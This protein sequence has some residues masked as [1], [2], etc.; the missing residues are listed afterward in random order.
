MRCVLGWLALCVGCYSPAYAPGGPCET[1]CPGD[2]VCIDHVCRERDYQPPGDAPVADA[3]VPVDTVDAP[4]GDQDGDGIDD[5]TDNCPAHANPDQ[6]DE[7]G[8]AI[9]DVCDPCPHVAGT[10]ADSDGDGVGDACDPQP[11]IAKQRIR[12]FDPFTSARPE[13]SLSASASRVGETLRIDAGS[14]G[15]SA[16]LFVPNGEARLHV[17]GTIVSVGSATPRQVSVSFGATSSS[18]YHYCELWDPGAVSIAITKRAGDDY[19]WIAQNETDMPMPTGPWAMRIDESVAAQ[20]IEISA[21][22]G[23]VAYPK[24]AADA[25]SAPPL[26]SGSSATIFARNVDVRLDYFIVIETLP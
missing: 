21:T 3:Y 25:S 22:L 23:G 12:F 2:L 15:G 18:V 14:S 4:P 19:M 9:G 20:H 7:D 6:H 11:N 5:A 24:L 17:G 1:S 10:A 26:A 16:Q 13:W 8:D